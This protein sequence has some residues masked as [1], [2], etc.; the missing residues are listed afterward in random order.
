MKGR[1]L[2]VSVLTASVVSLGACGASQPE[3]KPAQNSQ[4]SQQAANRPD[5]ANQ[6]NAYLTYEKNTVDIARKYHNSV[7]S[8]NV[9]VKGKVV[10]P[11][12]NVP[13]KMRRFFK[14]FS[15]FMQQQQEKRVERAA[16]SGFVVD[17]AGQIVTNYHV[18]KNS[19]KSGKA[20]LKDNAKITVQFAGS[21]DHLPVTVVGVNQSYDLALLQLKDSAQ[22]PK[23]TIPIPLADSNDVKVGQKAIAIGNPFGLESTVTQGIVSAINRRQPALVSGVPIPY[24]QTDAPI[25]PGN[26]GGPLVN[27]K[28]EVIGINDEI[29][30]PHGTFVG[31]GFAIPSSILK[32]NLEE[33][34]SG[35]FVKK[36]QL[37]I[38]I[39][40][41]K[42][43]PKNVR[44]YLNLPDYG[45]MVVGVVKGS[46]ADK[47]GL[48]GAQISVSSGGRE[49]PAGGDII[50][51]A[52][53][54]KLNSAKRLQNIVY[55]REAG[56]KV[57]LTILRDGKKKTIEA[58]L[59]VLKQGLNK[60]KH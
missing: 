53:G 46:P 11:L 47:I 48:K 28:G 58:K 33:L 6:N 23:D 49:W 13:P 51:K 17:S 10:N 32:K 16:G 18:I 34:K 50:L 24:I 21:G 4:S 56:D 35:G 9:T 30:A 37:G 29:L 15:P 52:E 25:N 26:S 27:S 20:K 5:T 41:V 36:A 40:S 43:Y 45:V 59:A 55:S 38:R 57:T 22:L 44:K 12:K 2:L 7:V 31:V 42:D 60:K 1:V 8:I 14:Q 3:S 54:K 19:L 39:I